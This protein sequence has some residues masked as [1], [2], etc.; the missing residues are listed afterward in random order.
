MIFMVIDNC[1]L[2]TR[3]QRAKNGSYLKRV[4]FNV[5]LFCLYRNLFKRNKISFIYVFQ[6][7]DG[8]YSSFFLINK[9]F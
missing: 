9:S 6:T 3:T 4:T 1:G 5:K 8:I 2:W 7:F